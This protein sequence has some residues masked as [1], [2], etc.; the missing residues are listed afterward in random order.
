MLKK[1]MVLA[2]AL[3]AL[4]VP[5]SAS[6]DSWADAGT[7]IEAGADITQP[8][9]GF[10]QFN[11]GPTGIFGCDVTVT[12]TTE[13][14]HVAEVTKFSPTTSTCVG[15]GAFKGCV[16]VKDTSNV[17]WDINNI[18]TPLVVTKLGGN[19]TIHYEFKE[20]SCAAAQ[21]TSHLE[22]AQI[23]LAVEGTNPI[24][25]LTFSGKSTSGVPIEGSVKPEGTATLG[26]AN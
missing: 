15:T 7:P 22:F 1:M 9:E 18:A 20:K 10:L 24:T 8:Y 19:P 13:G 21:T 11:T 17:P 6:A 3:A 25:K 14:P 2:M 4:A 5:A 26:L 16:L 23:N 12:I